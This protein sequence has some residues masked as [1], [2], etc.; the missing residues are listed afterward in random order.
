MFWVRKE[1]H[2]SYDSILDF[3]DHMSS[4]NS[5][6][7]EVVQREKGFEKDLNPKSSPKVNRS[8]FLMKSLFMTL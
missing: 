4:T 2:D 5:Q 7:L 6:T 8:I 1:K 3:V